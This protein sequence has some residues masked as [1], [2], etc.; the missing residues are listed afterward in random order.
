VVDNSV[1][2]NNPII[3]IEMIHF[4]LKIKN[5]PE[6]LI[7]A[8]YLW[9]KTPGANWRQNVFSDSQYTRDDILNENPNAKKLIELNKYIITLDSQDNSRCEKN[10]ILQHEFGDEP[11]QRIGDKVN[12][13]AIPYILFLMPKNI[14]KKL[15]NKMDQI[16][17]CLFIFHD[18]IKYLNKTLLKRIKYGPAY[19]QEYSYL[20][21]IEDPYLNIPP[22]GQFEIIIERIITRISV[23]IWY[24]DITDRFEEILDNFDIG[25]IMSNAMATKTTCSPNDDIYQRLLDYIIE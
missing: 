16:D 19:E 4:W 8:N 10:Y 24:K 15:I 6:E 7:K 20:S 5:N 18:G 12:I 22:N 1:W 3:P 17:D 23:S 14:S 21:E 2:D 25:Y 13:V 9:W 11:G